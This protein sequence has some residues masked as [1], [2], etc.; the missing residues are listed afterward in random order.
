MNEEVADTSSFENFGRRLA[1]S[2]PTQE[3]IEET[4]DMSS[5]SIQQREFE[6]VSAKA[7]QQE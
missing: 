4:D 2:H 1:E 7:G 3:D 6:M 5:Y